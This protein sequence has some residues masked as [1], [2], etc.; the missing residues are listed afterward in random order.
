LL[1]VLLAVENR[2]EHA[3]NTP[4]GQTG[5]KVRASRVIDRE[6]FRIKAWEYPSGF[7]RD[8]GHLL[9]PAQLNS[10]FFGTQMKIGE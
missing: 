9:E 4:V 5:R 10:G 7:S 6:N 1:A 2:A 8:K 3:V